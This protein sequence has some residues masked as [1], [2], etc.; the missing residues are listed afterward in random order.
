MKFQVGEI[1]IVAD[2]SPVLFD[3]APRPGDEVMIVE[4]GLVLAVDPR[5]IFPAFCNYT[6]EDKHGNRWY[7]KGKWLRKRRPPHEPAED[8]FQQELQQWLGAGGKA[9]ERV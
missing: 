2:G 3:D 7:T 6:T 8:E 5:S 1:A 9:G 4:C